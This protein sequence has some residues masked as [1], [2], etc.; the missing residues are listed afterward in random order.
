MSDEM[1]ERGRTSLER[2]D[3]KLSG[4]LLRLLERFVIWMT[5][6]I[7]LRLQRFLCVRPLHAMSIFLHIIFF[8]VFLG[9]YCMFLYYI[10]RPLKIYI[11]E[12]N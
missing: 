3:E 2:R 12:Y 1:I 4:Y 6:A 9:H 10:F 8:V 5:R 7:V 11:S